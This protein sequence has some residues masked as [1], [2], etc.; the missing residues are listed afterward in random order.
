MSSDENDVV[1]QRNTAKLTTSLPR[2]AMQGQ[3]TLKGSRRQSTE[4]QSSQ[5]ASATASS[6]H[7]TKDSLPSRKA[8]VSA[9]TDEDSDDDARILK[10]PRLLAA[11][12][13]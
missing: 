3:P 13:N 10:Q 7:S 4:S 1:L 12:V 5:S 9:T 2:A 8:V 6:R 11:K